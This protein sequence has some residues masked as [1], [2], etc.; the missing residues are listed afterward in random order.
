LSEEEFEAVLDVQTRLSKEV[1]EM[2]EEA[3][4][5]GDPPVLAAKKQL[6]AQAMERHPVSVIHGNTARDF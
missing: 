4:A 2:A 3:G 6:Q 1:T 5:K